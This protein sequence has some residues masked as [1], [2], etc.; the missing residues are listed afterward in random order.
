MGIKDKQTYG[1]YYWAMQVEAQNA[2]DED[3]ETAF[4][5]Y[6]R[7]LLADLPDIPELPAGMQTFIR[8]LAEPPSAGFGGFALGVGVEMVDE[9][10]HTLMNPMMKIMQRSINKRAK[11]TWLTSAESNR[12]FRRG[13]IDEPLWSLVAESEGYDEILAKFLYESQA[14]YPAIPEIML[15]ARY[16][17]DPENTKEIVWK[18]FDISA[19][20]Y[21]V[22]EWNTLQRLTTDQAHTLLRRGSFTDVEYLGELARIG[23][24]DYTR[25]LLSEIGWSVPN[26]MLMVQGDL[27]R[28]QD[29]DQILSDISK[30]DINPAYTQ[31][32]LDAVLTKPASQD[33]IAY[34][35]RKDP[36]LGDLDAKL[37]KIGIHSEYWPI[38]K[39]LAYQIPPVADIITMAVREAFTPAIAARFGQYEDFPEEFGKYAEMKG[40]T[41]EWAERYWAS[42]WALPS[43]QQGFTMLHRGVISQDELNMLLRAQDV[44]PFWRDKL[45]QIAYRPLTRVDVRRMYKQGVLN[46]QE[47]YESYLD[48]GYADENAKRMALFTVKQTLSSLAKFTSTDVV[49]AYVKRMIT[50]SEASSLLG[51]LDIRYEDASYILSTADYKRT[52]AFTDQQIKGIRN[53]YKKDIYDENKAQA[54]LLRLNLPSEQ[55]EVLMKQWWYEKK[56]VTPATWTTA[57]T[58]SFMKKGLIDKERAE[59]ELR[60]IG[61]DKEHINIYMGSVV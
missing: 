39:E 16:H 22:W 50:R 5:P 19:N 56:E 53:L 55:V 54:E 13:K 58:L 38:Y 20:D 27:Q 52:W 44:M 29:N 35:L 17:G 4:A 11:E 49:N 46:E 60:I 59:T 61:Y 34:E 40:L 7:G 15:Y 8:T 2:F 37:R 32:Y 3:I 25:Y 23:W 14:P 43:P 6:F 1:E 21:D 18:H 33:L 30:A 45:V 47:V 24:P 9:T 26:A 10:L 41:K 12:L 51:D 36:S 28:G 31:T 57:Q 42:H 48:Q